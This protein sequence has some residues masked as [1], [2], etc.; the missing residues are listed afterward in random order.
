MICE[1]ECSK[2]RLDDKMKVESKRNENLNC[3]SFLSLNY[4]HPLSLILPHRHETKDTVRVSN[5]FKMDVHHSMVV[6]SHIHHPL[7]LPLPLLV[8]LFEE[9]TQWFFD[10]SQQEPHY[11]CVCVCVI[12]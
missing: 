12:T 3:S 9:A 7:H 5:T 11:M 6:P 10:V 8:H 4:H 1:V 2:V